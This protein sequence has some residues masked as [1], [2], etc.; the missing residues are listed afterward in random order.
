VRRPG[1]VDFS[2]RIVLDGSQA[3]LWME[4]VAGRRQ[5][6][7]LADGGCASR[8]IGRV[9]VAQVVVAGAGG[10]G[11]IYAGLLAAAGVDVVVLAHGAHG[12]MLRRDDLELHLPGGRS[13]RVRLRPGES[14][15]AA[16]VLLTCR[17]FDTEDVL[18]RLQGRPE[19]AVSF[20]NGPA[21]N[22]AL[23][24][25]YGGDVVVRGASTV[26]AELVEPGVAESV[27][28]GVTYLDVDPRGDVLADLLIAAGMRVER[29]EGTS[30][31][32]SKLAF[33]TSMMGLQA[34]TRRFLHELMLSADGA[35]LVRSIC[36][37]V[38]AVAAASGSRLADLPGMLPVRTIAEG[39]IGTAEKLLHDEGE[40]LV[41]AGATSRRTS[42][43]RAAEAGKRTELDG[44]LGELVRRGAEAGL[45]LPTVETQWRL[46]RLSGVQA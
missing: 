45:S 18:D 5:V 13:L 12:E 37:E 29:V 34:I 38:A 19:V 22:N 31:E 44:I 25:R 40:K 27:G 24:R 23:A 17:L 42:L 2:V 15:G 8:G 4:V 36:G 3:A 32:W 16:V 30:A 39:D 9:A 20:Q 35:A 14:A 28:L 21:K 26:A 7:A 43:F 33:V 41:A 10:L 6:A 11:S 1:D 46:A